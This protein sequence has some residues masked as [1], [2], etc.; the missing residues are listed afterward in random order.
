MIAKGCTKSVHI[1]SKNQKGRVFGFDRRPCLI[2]FWGVL[3]ALYTEKSDFDA[4]RRC[5]QLTP[6]KRP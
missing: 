2:R 4:V 5:G 1:S 3:G 6:R